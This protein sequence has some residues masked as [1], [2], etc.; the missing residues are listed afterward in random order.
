[1]LTKIKCI[2]Y[3]IRFKILHFPNLLVRFFTK[4]TYYICEECNKIHKRDSKEVRLD[5][6]REHLMSHPL[7]YGSISRDCFI[8]QQR[9]VWESLRKSLLEIKD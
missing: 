2:Y 5:E 4:D 3:N 1:M 9:E 7:W 8:K 6:S